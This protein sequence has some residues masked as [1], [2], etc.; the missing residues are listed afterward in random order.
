MDR[1]LTVDEI[2]DKNAFKIELHKRISEPEPDF[3]ELFE[4][5]VNV[6]V[7]KRP[8]IWWTEMGKKTMTGILYIFNSMTEFDKFQSL[9]NNL[10][11]KINIIV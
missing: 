11:F 3:V 2:I 1:Y 4:E 10:K 6:A 9:N 7:N 5:Y 8:A